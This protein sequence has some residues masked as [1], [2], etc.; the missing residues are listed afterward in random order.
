M[1]QDIEEIEPQ[2]LENKEINKRKLQ[3][4]TKR[5][6]EIQQ[7]TQTSK[8]QQQELLNLLMSG[9]KPNN[10]IFQGQTN[11]QQNVHSTPQFSYADYMQQA[12]MQQQN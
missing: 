9:Y 1:N 2:L 8:Q 12:P 3:Q 7:E 11:Q 10:K 6:E 4:K 5:D